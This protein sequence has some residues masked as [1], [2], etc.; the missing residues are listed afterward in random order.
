MAKVLILGNVIYLVYITND[1]ST[2]IKHTHPI[3]YV[4]LIV[5]TAIGNKKEIMASDY[6]NIK[7]N[8]LSFTSQNLFLIP[9]IYIILDA[10]KIENI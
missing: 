10:T 1:S 5:K 8:E 7:V 2:L 6:M 9:S 4:N 3:V